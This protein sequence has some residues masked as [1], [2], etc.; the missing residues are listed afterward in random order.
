MTNADKTKQIDDAIEWFDNQM[1]H[2]RHALIIEE[3]LTLMKEQ[4]LQLEQVDVTYGAVR[5]PQAGDEAK[6]IK[7]PTPEELEQVM[8]LATK[9]V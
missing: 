5:R 2:N 6:D 7:H 9:Y 3:A 8:G 1:I 4:A